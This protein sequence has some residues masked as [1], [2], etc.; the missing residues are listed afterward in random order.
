[1]ACLVAKNVGGRRYWQIV[2][3]QRVD[4]KPRQVVLAHL[5]TA[6]A[7][8]ARLA[9]GPGVPQKAR[10][11]EFGLLAAAWNLATELDL[12]GTID[13]HVP[14]RHQGLSVGQYLLLA[15][16]NRLSAPT[17]KAG[18][19]EWYETT[20][21]RRW[22]P[23]PAKSLSSQRFWDHMDRLDEDAI[24]RIEAEVTRRLVERFGID[25]RCLCFDCTNF[26][27]FIDSRT[28]SELPQRG[29]A[30][31]KRT[32]LRVVGLALLV[33]IDHDIP[34]FW[35][36]YPGNQPD[37]VTMASV[38]A[39]LVERYRELARQTEHVTLVFDKGNNSE[40]NLQQLAE[41]P[42]H[43]VGSL[44]P[45]QHSDLLAIALRKF[46][47]LQDPRLTG[48]TAYRTRKEVFGRE[49]TLVV[50]RSQEL[51]EGQLR[52]IAQHLRKRREAL[53]ELRNR[54]RR[55][56][57]P[58]ARGKGYTL[59]SLQEHAA[60]LGRGQYIND[61]LQIE[62]GSRRNRLY[63]TYRTNRA[64]LDRLTRTVLGKRIL[65]TDNQDW[66]TEAIV[67]A[68]RS[69]YHVEAAFR[70]MKNPHWVSW[71]PLHHWTDQKIR[72]H[73]LYCVLALTLAGLLQRQAAR[74]GLTLSG[75]AIHDELN[76]I[77]E[78]LTLHASA[79]DDKGGRPRAYTS[80]VE[81]SA[82]GAK[83]ADIFGIDRLKAR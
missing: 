61:I 81:P 70:Q 22:L 25:L 4:G 2:T 45:S 30:K 39:E 3:S 77:R 66:S 34:L 59:E 73:A 18:M 67:L 33:S 78:V 51:L 76:S 32:D 5:G 56:Q 54:L 36:V 65:F 58:G 14:K 63:L 11:S 71:D 52:G 75:E 44:V 47:E 49:W 53:D 42:Y 37:S 16:L 24:G 40:D 12:A 38:T 23:V 9:S 35:R 60:R 46:T 29:H 57:Q 31:S 15:V 27:T 8:M 79:R 48:V 19:A 26:D 80:Y 43:I 64:A 72:V 21:L 82:V 83:L 28:P 20:A 13:R 68:Y 50:T 62:V 7:L 1:M 10:V 55:S 17:S 6:D 69:Q 41:S 74:A